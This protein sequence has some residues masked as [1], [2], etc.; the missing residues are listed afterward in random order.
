[1]KYF[2]SITIF[3]L[4]FLF[5]PSATYPH[6]GDPVATQEEIASSKPSSVSK[7]VEATAPMQKADALT[8]APLP[9]QSAEVVPTVKNSAVAQRMTHLPE[10]MSL[11]ELIDRVIV[12]E[13]DEVTAINLY[14]P[15]V[16]TYIQE[17]KTDKQ[18]GLVPKSDFYFIGQM[19]YKQGDKYN[20]MIP[21]HPFKSFMQSM[22]PNGW[23]LNP[24]S[25]AE[26]VFIDPVNF[27]KT[28][29]KITYGGES[30]LGEVR[31]FMFD[32]EPRTKKSKWR[33]TGRI[34]V[35]DK[36][37]TIIRINGVHNPASGLSLQHFSEHS[38]VHF[39]SWRTNVES[40]LW[41]PTLVFT[42]EV[43][44]KSW[45]T[46]VP[47]M[48]SQTRYWGYKLK[49]SRHEDEFAN[50]TIESATAVTEDQAAHD[51]SPLEAQREWRKEAE[52]NVLDTLEKDGLI[53]PPGPVDKVLNTIINNLE[54]SAELADQIDLH[55]RI[56]LTGTLEMFSIGDTIVVS[57][58]LIDVTPDEGTMAAML[59]QEI[60]DALVP[61][62]YTDQYGFS[63]LLRL[64]P[65]EAIRRLSFASG[66]EEVKNLDEKVIEILKASP[67][68][69]HLGSAGLFLEQLNSQSKSLKQLISP[70]LG[71]R[72]NL[73]Q[74][75]TKG[76][77][78]LYPM[79][80]N[81]RAALPIGSRTKLDPWT[82]KLELTKTQAPPLKSARE[83]MP[84]E[85]T[86]FRPYVTRAPQQSVLASSPNAPVES[87]IQ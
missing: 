12:R 20:S 52:R 2:Y 28:D 71:N 82:N 51:R 74:S 64:T 63:D 36:D 54:V 24:D 83:K 5:L 67:Y 49:S 38:D 18:L 50:M 48:K 68:A 76:A 55:A 43:E 22:M 58:G 16:E 65:T 25:F 6:Q 75:L 81:Q 60:A 27:N 86:P 8:L 19:N 85:I 29:Y 66:K 3:G 1:M 72:V 26:K 39:D 53:A 30:F 33:F 7:S 42:E 69:G 17:L 9:R 87:R 57:R 21:T 80:I 59:A 23:T 78:T 41:L 34:W 32:V 47:N 4:S 44:P 62:P 10:S 79:D 56:L 77:P 45:M 35:E 84:F 46:R 37:F 13:H 31:C 40:G 73:A 14:T 61:N 15:I 11:D 70:R